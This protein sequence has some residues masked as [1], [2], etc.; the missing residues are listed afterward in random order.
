MIC[1]IFLVH[2]IKHPYRNRNFVSQQPNPLLPYP[3]K[4]EDPNNRKESHRI[5]YGCVSEMRICPY[6]VYNA[7]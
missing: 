7:V 4:V 1:V 2:R 5:L 6:A 3:K